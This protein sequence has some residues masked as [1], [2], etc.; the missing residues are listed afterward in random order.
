MLRRGAAVSARAWSDVPATASRFAVASRLSA[1]ALPGPRSRRLPLATGWARRWLRPDALCGAFRR[2]PC[3]R[4]DRGKP[5]PSEGGVAGN[6][7]HQRVTAA[8]VSRLALP[9]QPS[10]GVADRQNLQLDVAGGATPQ[11]DIAD[12]G[13]EQRFGE[14]RYPAHPAVLG[15]ELVL[16]DDGKLALL[17]LRIGDA[18]RGAEGNLLRLLPRRVDRNRPL[19]PGLEVTDLPLGM[20]ERQFAL[21]AAGRLQQS[22]ALLLRRRETLA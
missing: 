5:P 20:G 7:I 11:N 19:D 18:N 4:H 10:G 3:C 12:A 6:P 8:A 15:V 14:R 16:A 1:A 13:A 17:V 9:V 21:D 22:V 2:P